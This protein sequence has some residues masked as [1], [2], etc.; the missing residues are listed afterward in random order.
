MTGSHGVLQHWPCCGGTTI[1]T[2]PGQ[3]QAFYNVVNTGLPGAFACTVD[4]SMH[5]TD[6]LS[7]T[8]LRAAAEQMLVFGGEQSA[9]TRRAKW[10]ALPVSFSVVGGSM[11]LENLVVEGTVETLPGAAMLVLK[12]IT[13]EGEVNLSGDATIECDTILPL[14]TINAAQAKT[15]SIVDSN[16][17]GANINFGYIGLVR[18][19]TT[20]VGRWS[21]WL[22]GFARSNA[23]D[24]ATGTEFELV[25]IQVYDQA[26]TFLGVFDGDQFGAMVCRDGFQG[27]SCSIDIDECRV[28]SGGCFD[29]R[30]DSSACINS[31]GSHHCECRP[32]FSPDNVEQTQ[33]TDIDECTVANG[34]CEETCFNAPV[35]PT[36]SSHASSRYLNLSLRRSAYG[37]VSSSVVCRTRHSF[38]WHSLSPTRNRRRGSTTAGVEVG[39][40]SARIR[41]AVFVGTGISLCGRQFSTLAIQS[42]SRSHARRSE[43]MAGAAI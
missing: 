27:P 9:A 17:K 5:H 32:G 25:A 30:Y 4:R 38:S 20:T 33:C 24:G 39:E 22:D 15:L 3:A 42:F 18:A 36:F 6:I 23:T 14:A 40:C 19:H 13:L 37:I 43:R 31:V 26:D 11:K 21:H 29:S 7:A 2:N 41:K 35:R 16:F 1:A 12:A 10:G 8:P 34:G 28:D